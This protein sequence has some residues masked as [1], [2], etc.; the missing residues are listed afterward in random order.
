MTRRSKRELERRLDA[1]DGG[2]P[3]RRGLAVAWKDSETG[4]LYAAPCHEERLPAT[5]D[6]LMV[7]E[8]TVVETDWS[9]ERDTDAL[10]SESQTQ[11]RQ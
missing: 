2:G 5:A 11:G 7:I 4:E 6:P 3:A 8:E 10:D 9:C 1:L